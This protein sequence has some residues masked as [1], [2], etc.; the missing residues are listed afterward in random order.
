MPE[1]Q[2]L[3]RRLLRGFPPAL[4]GA[5]DQEAVNT[6]IH[7]H[8][9][10]DQDTWSAAAA[11]DDG[12]DDDAD[13]RRVVSG[14][15]QALGSWQAYQ[16]KKELE[17]GSSPRHHLN[18]TA[19]RRKNEHIKEGVPSTSSR[20]EGEQDIIDTP[21]SNGRQEES[22]SV[23][24]SLAS[25]SPPRPPVASSVQSSATVIR[26][27]SDNNNMIGNSVSS[28]RE[29][30]AMARGG[31][32]NVDEAGGGDDEDR[33]CHVLCVHGFDREWV[34]GPMMPSAIKDA[35]GRHNVKKVVSLR[36]MSVPPFPPTYSCRV[37]L[38]PH[39]SDMA[40][41]LLSRGDLCLRVMSG[42]NN[43]L[44]HGDL[45]E[46]KEMRVRVSGPASEP[47]G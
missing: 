8:Q 28:L 15:E 17:E 12:T 24:T 45:S 25:P 27:T 41:H 37:V 21:N 22:P 6:I 26:L 18:D 30:P 1:V 19:H 29:S 2:S 40:A 11:G 39:A 43:A 13:D 10:P 16:Q 35:I 34:T 31:R 33:D 32:V 42:L 36:G 9:H 20:D 14:Y 47:G 46:E 44:P 3:R 4:F 23:F 38:H 7:A 5:A